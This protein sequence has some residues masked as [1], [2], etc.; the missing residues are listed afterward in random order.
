MG[1]HPKY[2]YVF[3]QQLKLPLPELVEVT[4]ADDWMDSLLPKI[5]GLCLVEI[6]RLDLKALQ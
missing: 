3:R 5:G 1:D 6:S 4:S 2:R